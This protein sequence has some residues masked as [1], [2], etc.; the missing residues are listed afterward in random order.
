[1]SVVMDGRRPVRFMGRRIFIGIIAVLLAGAAAWGRTPPRILLVGD[2]W[3][4]GVWVERVM[5]AAFREA[6]M[7]GIE[8]AGEVTALG[9]TR[10]EQWVKPEYREKIS[11]EL[12]KYPSIDS[13]HL[14]IG[15][16]DVLKRI[17]ETNVFEAWDEDRRHRE[18]RGIANNVRKI[19]AHCLSFPQ[20]RHVVIGGYDYLNAATARDFYLLAGQNFDF[21]GM[22]QAQVNQCF[23]EVERLK[24]EA[25]KGLEGCEYVHNFGLAQHFFGTPGGAPAPGG[26]PEYVPFPGGN[27]EFPMPDKAFIKVETGGLTFAGD[28]VH[29]SGET[30]RRMIRNAIEHCYRKWYGG[31]KQ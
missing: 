3:A 23:I 5:E 12:K 27:P 13:V 28:G 4:Q 31:G 25:V 2:S 22:T 16:N 8:C 7:E 6:G 19:A 30:H 26:A 20:V 14:I 11:S 9:G 29:P 10:A 18:W 15:G 21:G 24:L 1:M 17:R